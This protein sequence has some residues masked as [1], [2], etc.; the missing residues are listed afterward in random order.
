[1]NYDQW[2]IYDLLEMRDALNILRKYETWAIEK[3]HEV[4]Q[5]LEKRLKKIKNM[6][7]CND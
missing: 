3:Y 5:E 4:C 6:G 2:T 1:M 7:V